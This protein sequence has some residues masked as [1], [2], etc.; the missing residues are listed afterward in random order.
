MAVGKDMKAKVGRSHYGRGPR[1]NKDNYQNPIK[2]QVTI[3]FIIKDIENQKIIV[4]DH[5]AS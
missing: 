2:T 4:F 3:E 1:K 5:S